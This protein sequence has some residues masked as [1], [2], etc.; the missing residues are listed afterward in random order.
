ML[1]RSSNAGNYSGVTTTTL[2]LSGAALANSGDQ[3]QAVV[4][5]GFNGGTSVTSNAATLTVQ[6]GPIFTSASST[7]FTVNAAGSFTVAATGTPAPTYSV[8]SGTFPGWASLNTNTGV[9]SGTPVNSVGSPFSFVLQ[10]SNGVGAAATQNF[11]L[12]VQAA[13]VI[14]TSPAS[15]SVALG[16]NVTFSVVATGSPAPTT[17]QWQ[18]QPAGT[19]G[20][21][22]LVDGSGIAGA[23]TSALTVGGATLAM[24]GDQFQ[25]VV[26]NGI[27]ASTSAVATLTVPQ[28]PAITSANSAYFVVGTAGTF[29]A[30]A[31]GSPAVT[32]SVASGT[33]PAWASLNTS[34]GVISGTPANTVGS[35]FTFVLQAANGV[36]PAATQNFTL[37]RSE[38]HTSELQSH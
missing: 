14:G 4:T 12:T 36:S 34:T 23:T 11:T 6:Q 18:R 28:A 15:Q 31:T 37:T 27:A 1:F 35:P 19:T 3:F 17:Y 32:F 8:A 9:I 7:S 22:N 13:P 24:S 16:Q 21:V 5:N 10:A 29:T 25:V 20:F 2:T 33:F 26:G 38:E 30:T